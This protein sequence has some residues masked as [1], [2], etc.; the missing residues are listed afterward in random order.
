MDRHHGANLMSVVRVQSFGECRGIGAAMPVAGDQFS[1]ETEP[2]GDLRPL[3]GELSV[4]EG[5]YLVTCTQ[6]V[7]ERGFPGAGCRARKNRHVGRGL[8][9]CF[10]TVDASPGQSNRVWAAM[11]DGGICNGVQNP[12]RDIGGSGELKKMTAWLVWH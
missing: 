9:N 7:D 3:E 12:V 5:E 11:V 2:A 6:S 1:G 8:E 10:H 4:I